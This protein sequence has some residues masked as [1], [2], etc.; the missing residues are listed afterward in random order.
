MK[1]ILADIS[2][3]ALLEK[4]IHGLTKNQNQSFNGT[5]WNRIPKDTHVGLRQLE[6]G[7]YDATTHFNIGS[8][9]AVL[10]YEKLGMRPGQ[11]TLKGCLSKNESR[12]IN[13]RRQSTISKKMRRR[14][15]RAAKKHKSDK[16]KSKEVKVYGA[17]AF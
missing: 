14:Y 5:V 16:T 2:S 8:K 4:C 7:V 6:I 15:N 3:V 13:A 1:P 17:G 9:D 10:V 11:H 12:T